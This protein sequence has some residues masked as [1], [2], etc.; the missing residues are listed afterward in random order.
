MLLCLRN[1][2]YIWKSI[3]SREMDKILEE[4][5]FTLLDFPWNQCELLRN[6]L[7]HFT[8]GGNKK[9]VEYLSNILNSLGKQKI[10]ILSDST[11]GYWN[12]TKKLHYDIICCCGVGYTTYPVN[13]RSLIW[14]MN[15]KYDIVLVIGGWNDKYSSLDSVDKYVKKFVRTVSQKFTPLKI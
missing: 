6:D 11:L 4:N 5:G 12:S 15:N 14:D 7:D 8:E 2:V 3:F 10:L 1:N 9:F 13:F